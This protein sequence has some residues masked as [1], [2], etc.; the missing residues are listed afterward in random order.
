MINYPCLGFIYKIGVQERLK[1]LGF[2]FD[3]S[4]AKYFIFE[5]QDGKYFV[6]TEND[7]YTPE[8]QELIHSGWV[9]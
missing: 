4:E 8:T 6:I 9:P 7:W 3:F 2:A 5:D 1:Y